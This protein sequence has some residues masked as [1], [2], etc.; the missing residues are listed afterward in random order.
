VIGQGVE[1]CD[2]IELQFLIS[3]IKYFKLNGSAVDL[4]AAHTA[5]D[6]VA[7]NA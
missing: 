7:A 4:V 6:G 3:N 2:N 5:I 1:S